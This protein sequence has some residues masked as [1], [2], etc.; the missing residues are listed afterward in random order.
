MVPVAELGEPN[1]YP[2]PAMTVNIAVS[3]GSTLVS[4]T[5]S[6]VTV[7]VVAPGA[8]IT[9]PVVEKLAAPDWV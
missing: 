8:K 3:L 1:K 7:A 4:L 5:G 6:S 9:V 2:V